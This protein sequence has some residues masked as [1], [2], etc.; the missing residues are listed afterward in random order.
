LISTITPAESI[1]EQSN[2]EGRV[3]ASDGDEKYLYAFLENG[4]KV[5]VMAGRW[6]TIKN[7]SGSNETDF[8]WHHIGELTLSNAS[9]NITAVRMATYSGTRYL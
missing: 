8:W 4:T 5:Q 3:M 1:P 2:F 9:D 7:A 6:E